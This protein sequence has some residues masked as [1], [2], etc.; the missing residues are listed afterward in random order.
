MRFAQLQII[1]QVPSTVSPGETVIQTIQLHFQ[2]EGVTDIVI[3]PMP[4][5][6]DQSILFYQGR[7]FHTAM[8]PEALMEA[9]GGE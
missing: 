7:E 3:A 5:S 1:T 6:P 8:S 9:F 4:S 2:V